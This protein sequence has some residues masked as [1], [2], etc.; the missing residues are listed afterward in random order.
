VD[1]SHI[2]ALLD[3]VR[4]GEL[5][6]ADAVDRLR[7]LPFADLEGIARLDHHRELRAGVPEIVYGESKSA[8]D[9]ARLLGALAEGGGGALATRVSSEKA[10]AIQ[11]AVPGAIYHSRGRCVVIEPETPRRAGRGSVGVVCAGTSDLP[12]ADEAAIAL[13]FLGHPVR[14]AQDIGIAGLH[15]VVDAA[16]GLRDCT[17][18]IAVAGF[19][20]ALP[21]ALAG[22]IPGPI[23]AVPTSVGYGVGLGG[24]AAMVTMLAGCSPGVVVVNID[25]GL[26]AA[27]AAARINAGGAP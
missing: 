24:F 6:V 17:V 20:G 23:I 11:A 22:L 9:I 3:A 15:R 14:R 2:T 7:I 13:E 18:C 4:S 19:E 26:G 10:A 16:E 25:N 8:E 1:R 5:G 21:G 27:V 12:V